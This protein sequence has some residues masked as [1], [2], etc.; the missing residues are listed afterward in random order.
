[1]CLSGRLA[2]LHLSQTF[3]HALD[4]GLWFEMGRSLVRFQLPHAAD[5]QC[6]RLHRVS[7]GKVLV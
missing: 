7:P 6:S 2:Q 4:A 3:L 5:L 1:M